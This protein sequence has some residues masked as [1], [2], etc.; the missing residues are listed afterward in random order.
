M[1]AIS[2][3]DRVSENLIVAKEISLVVALSP[4]LQTSDHNA[5]FRKCRTIC[6]N[7]DVKI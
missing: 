7:V 5:N 6:Y 3:G 2:I 4:E 1:T